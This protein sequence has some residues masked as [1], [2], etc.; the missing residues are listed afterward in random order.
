MD[1]IKVIIV[2]DHDTYR[3]GVRMN[4]ELGHPDIAVVGEAKSGAEFFD[5][6][7]TVEAVDIVL[8]DIIFHD[9]SGIS[10]IDIAR[11][12][13]NERPEIKIL[14]ISAENSSETIT[15]MLQIGIDGFINKTNS[16]LDT[17]VEA[18]RSIMEGLEYF[19]RD[20]AAIISRIVLAKKKNEK[21]LAEFSE[22]EIQLIEYCHEGLSAKLI[23]D[24]MGVVLGTVNWHKGKIFRKL[25]INSTAEMVQY[26]LKK[27]IIR[28]K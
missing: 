24:R 1:K 18:I 17:P 21:D 7:K 3:F 22:Q 4:I 26:A 25:G 5:L 16:T 2:D 27:G 23:A 20:I 12:L 10:G 14:A 19:G 13:K 28:V 11:R 15:E 8:L 6:L 9:T